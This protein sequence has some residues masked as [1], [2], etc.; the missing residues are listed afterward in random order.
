[1]REIF[2]ARLPPDA[3]H[4]S[5]WAALLLALVLALSA[6]AA[7]VAGQR[8]APRGAEGAGQNA[9]RGGQAGRVG[10]GRGAEAA[11]R[12]RL[13]LLV[14][15]DQFRYDFLE[16]FGDLFGPGGL[17]RLQREGASWTGAHYD[18][19][20]TETAPGHATLL[21]GAWPSETGIIANDWYDRARGRRVNN[22]EDETARLVG[23]GGAKERAA[24]PRSLLASTLGD[25]LKLATGGRSK[26]IGISVKD[27]GAVL[28]AGRAADGAFWYSAETGQFV[29]SNYYFNQLPAWVERY[30]EGR[31]ADRYFGA[32]WERLLPPAEYGRRA[33]ADDPS[34]EKGDG[35]TPYVFPYA[36]GG[37]ESRPGPAFYNALLYSPYTND[38][39]VGLAERAIEAERLGADDET[40][41]LSVS[42]S[43]NDYVGHRYGPYSHE[44]MDMTLRTDRQVEQLLGIVDARVGLRN[45]LVVFTSDHGVAPMVDMAA[46]T[47]LPGGRVKI[48]EM[49]NAIRSRLRARYGK[50]G[51][52][53]NTADYIHIYSN[54]QLYFNQSALERDGVRPEEAER[55]AGEAALTVP[56]VMRYFTRS[57][58]QNGAISPADPVARRALHGYSPARSGDVIILQE[59]FKYITEAGVSATHGTPY[60]YDTHVPLIIM[61]G[62][63]APGRYAEPATPAD[64]AP[65][66]A[67]L[68]RVQ[69]PSNVTGRV[70]TEA[71][72]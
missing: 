56:G 71:L 69:P 10:A 4:G 52:R 25:E 61:G 62:G 40:D 47:R 32:K 30:N 48:S 29:S 2:C 46:G 26:V 43:A 41:V 15:V 19:I 5:R 27:R 35:K 18:H 60:S 51:D 3:A 23:P 42:L 59:P 13:V 28:P 57:Q 8:R 64:I 12:A 54:G 49:L 9:G 37:G 34:W 66:L 50:G 65:T 24:S 39:L 22:V 72:R 1:M 14:V 16:R 67:H 55:V 7:P 53:D 38:M 21:T 11:G 31:P 68:L 45:T 58:L 33:G 70:L 63:L 44:V 36:F 20:P 17:R 6:S